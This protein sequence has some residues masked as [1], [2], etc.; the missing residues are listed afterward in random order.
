M[1]NWIADMEKRKISELNSILDKLKELKVNVDVEQ[2]D[3][4]ELG[5]ITPEKQIDYLQKKYDS[6][7]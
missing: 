3:M 4:I 1:F 7:L 5:I 6:I 2:D